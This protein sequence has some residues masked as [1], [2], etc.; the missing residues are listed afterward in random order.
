MSQIQPPPTYAE[1][2]I[3]GS[4]G[5]PF[6][7]PIWLDWFIT[8]AAVI[9]ASGGASG[10]LQHNNL[11]GLQGGTTNEY[12]H[13][14]SAQHTAIGTVTSVGLTAPAELTVTGVPVTSSGTI[15]LTWAT[16]SAG[17][18]FSGPL[19]G[20]AAAPSFKTINAIA[21]KAAA[22]TQT[23]NIVLTN[24][25]DLL[26]AIGANE[27]WVGRI[28]LAVSA[29]IKTTGIQIS[30]AAPAGASGTFSASIVTDA[31]SGQEVDA[32]VATAIGSAANF[33]AATLP[34]SDN[35]FIDIIFRV[36]NGATPG[37]VNLQWA[38]STSSATAL[39]V[40]SASQLK[41]DRLA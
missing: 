27:T 38:Q 33:T 18:V 36:A 26:F 12:Y 32:I 40:R 21:A 29:A 16:E 15:A 22:T 35:G 9:S 6:F 30:V 20:A 3:T 37:N 19:S 11:G 1:V 23:S 25:P 4:D 17:T 28:Y 31:A 34:N 13:L 5:Q 41:A 39:S 10:Q 7:N 14:T 8:L 24:D 2:V